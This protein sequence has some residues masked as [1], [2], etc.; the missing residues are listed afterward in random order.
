MSNIDSAE[1]MELFENEYAQ[2]E[3]AKDTLKLVKNDLKAYAA[4]IEVEPKIINAA[5]KLFKNLKENPEAEVSADAEFV[6]GLVEEYFQN[7]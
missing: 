6:K 4:K 3:A 7:N 1:L 2:E 5:Y